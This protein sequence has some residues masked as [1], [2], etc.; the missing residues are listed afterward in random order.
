MS[1]FSPRVWACLLRQVKEDLQFELRPVELEY[2][3]KS[4]SCRNAATYSFLKHVSMQGCTEQG[5]CQA[6]INLH[7]MLRQVK[8]D[9]RCNFKASSDLLSLNVEE[10][11]MQQPRTYTS[12]VLL[13]ASSKK[14]RAKRASTV[15]LH[16]M[17]RQVKK[18]ASSDLL[19]LNAQEFIMQQPIPS[20]I[21]ACKVATA[22]GRAKPTSTYPTC[23]IR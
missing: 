12:L 5:P 6:N 9:R 18:P 14:G 17:L 1:F 16:N 4:S 8:E 13:Q 11:I 22:T 15:N 10:F 20:S 23:C 21:S 3:W 7:G 19:S 2:G